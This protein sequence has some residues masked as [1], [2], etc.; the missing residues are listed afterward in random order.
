MGL[1]ICDDSVRELAERLAA[2]RRITVT[3]A[4]RR[5]LERELERDRRIRESWARLD[6]MPDR[7]FGDDDMYDEIGARSSGQHRYREQAMG[8][9]IRDDTVRDMA[10]RLAEAR[11]TTV[12]EAVRRAIERD[13]A[14]L[15]QDAQDRER[16]LDAALARLDALPRR[17]V[18]SDYDLY[19][20]QGNPVL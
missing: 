2:A 12:T 15:Q 1:F 9:F 13:F 16:R 11:R 18:T 7:E 3:E 19:D 14:E 10:R 5:A 8:L 17:K 6:A 4:V 20:D